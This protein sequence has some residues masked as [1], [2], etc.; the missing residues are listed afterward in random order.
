MGPIASGIQCW[1][2]YCDLQGYPYFPPSSSRVCA[3]GSL[4]HPGGTFA[5]YVAHLSK[6]C[7][8]LDMPTGRHDSS[9]AAVSRGLR[10]AQNLSFMF[11]NYIFRPDLIRFLDYETLESEFGMVGFFSF[12][13]P[14]RVQSE[15]LPMRRAN[16]NDDILRRTPQKQQA[17]IGL[18]E[19][20]GDQRLVLKLNTRKN[21][22]YGSINMRPCF[23]EGGV[24]VPRSLCPVHVAWPIIR[25]RVLLGGLLFPSLQ[26][27]NLN[28]VLKAIMGKIGFPESE[29]YTTYAFRRGCL[30]EMKRSQ[31]TVAQI[32]KTAD[33]PSAQFKVYLDLMEDEEQVI[34]SLLR[35][36][37]TNDESND[38]HATGSND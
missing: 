2:A 27:T 30:M 3:W 10:K 37:D 11:P 6:A 22:R 5:Q 4:F 29:R 7:Q 24:L 12:L 38:E 15:G 33:W 25:A 28:R 19:V 31:A 32:M 34:K 21:T 35:T 26:R 14:L 36:L 17:L 20:A 18:R 23:C 8:L 13:I 9:V 16:L 1:V